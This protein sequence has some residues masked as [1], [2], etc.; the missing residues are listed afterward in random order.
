MVRRALGVCSHDA[1]KLHALKGL[2]GVQLVIIRGLRQ[3]EG[4]LWRADPLVELVHQVLLG[5]RHTLQAGLQEGPHLLEP[6]ELLPVG[7]LGRLE[8]RHEP[9]L[10]RVQDVVTTRQGGAATRCAGALG[11]EARGEGVDGGLGRVDRGSGLL[12]VCLELPELLTALLD[13]GGQRPPLINFVLE[14]VEG[15]VA[16]RRPHHA[17]GAARS[18]RVIPAAVPAV[19]DPSSRGRGSAG[20][21]H[22]PRPVW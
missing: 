9:V 13:D 5:L 18:Q 15:G 7:R 21:R 17:A 12:D 6:L 4:A 20:E 19:P 8:L 14:A 22:G 10:L 3:C 2:P 1:L 16:L 11:G